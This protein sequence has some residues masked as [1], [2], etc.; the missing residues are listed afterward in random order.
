MPFPIAQ[1]VHYKNNPLVE[2]VCQFRFPPILKIDTEVPGVFQD[3]VREK[4]PLYFEKLEIS[5]LSPTQPL[6]T[7]KNTSK[8]YE[9]KDEQ[10]EYKINLTRTFL[11]LSTKKYSQWEEFYERIKFMLDA[12][13]K[14]YSVVHF[15]R[16]GLRYINLIRLKELGLDG[17]PWEELIQPY[18]IGLINSPVSKNVDAFEN[19]SEVILEDKVSKAR[20]IT[21]F[22]L[23]DDLSDKAFV[24]DTD[25]SFNQKHKLP[26]G[27][28]KLNF[29]HDRATRLIRF[30]IHERLHQALIPKEI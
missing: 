8:N 1:R 17:T 29:F 20:I 11:S 4:F 14:V 13:S 7:Q 9:F 3:L 16:V 2:V 27:I 6:N 26:E 18:F 28:D 10:D 5:Y 24:I 23:K 12:F 30:A 19:T 25:F 21:G 22:A 15:T